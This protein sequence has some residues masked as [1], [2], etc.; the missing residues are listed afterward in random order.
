M[1]AG[2]TVAEC[3]R[4]SLGLLWLAVLRWLVGSTWSF[5]AC[6]DGGLTGGRVMLVGREGS[7]FLQLQPGIWRE[8]LR[9]DR[10]RDPGFR[11]HNLD[12]Q[13]CFLKQNQELGLKNPEGVTWFCARS[14]EVKR[15]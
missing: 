7:P 15:N 11:D 4:R 2:P 13:V 8:S 6:K 9:Q 14:L 1:A 12:G 10:E 5:S 3:D